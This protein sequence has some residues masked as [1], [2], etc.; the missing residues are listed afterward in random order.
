MTV[1]E[2]GGGIRKQIGKPLKRQTVQQY[3]NL[4]EDY[5]FANSAG[6]PAKPK[7]WW[8]VPP[9]G[10]SKRAALTPFG[11]SVRGAEL[12]PP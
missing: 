10:C 4:L 3:L 5:G 2:I 7:H 1:K 9:E 12:L 11:R 8:A 6:D